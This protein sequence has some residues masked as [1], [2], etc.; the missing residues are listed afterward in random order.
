MPLSAGTRLGPYEITGL[1]GA[2]GMGEVYRARDTRLDRTVAVKVTAGTVKF[3]HHPRRNAA[4]FTAT[5]GASSAS[6]NHIHRGDTSAIQMPN[7]MPNSK[8]SR[9]SQNACRAP[10]ISIVLAITLHTNVALETTLEN[11][12]INE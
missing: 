9:K 7:G 12:L 11:K 5:S 1:I 6:P 8:I 2:G 4:K 3:N 10:R